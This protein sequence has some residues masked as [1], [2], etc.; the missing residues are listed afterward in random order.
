MFVDPW[1]LFGRNTVLGY[2]QVYNADVAKAQNELVWLGYMEPI[3]DKEKGFFGNKT[4][5]AVRSFQKDRNLEVDG[6]IGKNTWAALGLTFDYDYEK[7]I[8]RYAQDTITKAAYIASNSFTLDDGLNL[9]DVEI[10]IGGIEK[11]H[12]KTS[13]TLDCVSGEAKIGI[14]KDFVG[15]NMRVSLINASINRKFNLPFTD[16][17]LTVGLE[18]DAFG[19]GFKTYYDKKDKEIKTGIIPIFGGGISYEID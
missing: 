12:E 17:T 10:G 15:I 11:E 16:K 4:D 13:W 9:I 18:G 5:A 7:G 3:P 14:S 2:S 6:L 19:I 8:Y 1:G